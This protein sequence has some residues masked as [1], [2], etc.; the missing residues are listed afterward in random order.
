MEELDGDSRGCILSE[1]IEE[2]ALPFLSGEELI[3][4]FSSNTLALREFVRHGSIE[5]T[6]LAKFGIRTL[7]YHVLP[8]EEMFEES[9][10]QHQY[11][12]RPR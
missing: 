8:C 9:H 1:K 4:P 7:I 10:T 11:I 6:G 12:S 5:I 3:R 2:L